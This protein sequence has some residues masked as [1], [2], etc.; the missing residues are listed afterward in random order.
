MMPYLDVNHLKVFFLDNKKDGIPIFFIHGFLGNIGDWFHQYLHFNPNTHTIFIDIPGFGR[1]DKPIINYSLEFY[2]SVLISIIESLRYEKIYLIG[3]SFGGMI[4][5]QIT[6]TKP[7]IV[8]KLILIDTTYGFCNSFTDKIKLFFVNLFFK[9]YY[10]VFLRAIIRQILANSVEKYKIKIY[11]KRALT[12]PKEVLLSTFKN[13]TLKSNMKKKLSRISTPTLIIHGS[14]DI[15]I[16]KSMVQKMNQLIP[17]SQVIYIEN[18]PHKT[19]S[20]NHSEVNQLIDEFIK[21]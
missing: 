2:S 19:M 17:S 20:I 7:K 3:H 13:M 21:N 12:I 8:E 18:G 10:K 15:I 1:S 4:A 14:R 16:K 9:I 11:Y 5:Q 6:I